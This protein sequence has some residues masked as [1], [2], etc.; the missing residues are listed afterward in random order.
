MESDDPQTNMDNSASFNANLSITYRS[1][2]MP[3]PVKDA[4]VYIL[5]LP[6]VGPRP[7]TGGSAAV[8]IKSELQAYLEPLRANRSIL[9]ILT[10]RL[11]PEPGSPCGPDVETVARARDL[12]MRQLA[13]EG[14]MEMS[15]VLGT[16]EAT[17]DNGGKL[18]V[19]S[20]LR[21]HNNLVLG[22]VVK[23]QGS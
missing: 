8:L 15:E 9:L 6:A 5:H 20:Q 13:G 18:V 16:I 22:L 2:G 17:R 11:L 4:A 10:S 7:S 21:G 14:E 3:Q 19:T 23:H 12:C 1:P